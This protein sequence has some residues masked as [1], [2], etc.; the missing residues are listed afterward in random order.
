MIAAVDGDKLLDDS[1]E[2]IHGDRLHEMCVKAC[3]G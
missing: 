3:V 1:S 2:R